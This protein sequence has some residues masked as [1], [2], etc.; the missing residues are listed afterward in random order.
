MKATDFEFSG[1]QNFGMPL[2]ASPVERTMV[3]A[4]AI[5]SA[6]GLEASAWWDTLANIAKTALPM[7]SS[8]AS[9][10]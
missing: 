4:G 8:I 2:Q 5:S 6:D 1:K 3:G 9:M 10:L 7:A